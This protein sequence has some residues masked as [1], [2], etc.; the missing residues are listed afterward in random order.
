MDN[1]LEKFVKEVKEALGQNLKSFILYGSAAADDR[2]K[3]SDLNT[4]IVVKDCDIVTLKSLHGPF[5]KW[6]KT[7]N[8]LPLLFTYERIKYADDIFPIEF[9]DIKESHALLA[10]EDIFKKMKIRTQNLRLEIE[11]EMKSA[12]L[13]LRSAYVLTGGSGKEVIKLMRDSVTTFTVIFKAIIRLYGKKAPVKKWDIIMNMPKNF[14][15][16]HSIFADVLALKEG[17]ATVADA[18]IFF[19]AY[20]A[21]IERVNMIIDR[22][23]K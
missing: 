8:P 11:R 1:K 21:E 20:M 15:V 6:K 14:K 17:R 7:G 10:G 22:F 5:K 2:Y 9:L 3:T 4:L 16:N 19:S 23:K 12:I 13:R 18:N